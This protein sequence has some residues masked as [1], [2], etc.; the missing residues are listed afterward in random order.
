MMKMTRRKIKRAVMEEMAPKKIIRKR[1]SNKSR[2]MQV[3]S[4]SY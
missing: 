1:R 4:R 2:K 3:N